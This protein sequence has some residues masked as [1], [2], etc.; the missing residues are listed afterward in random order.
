MRQIIETGRP[1]RGWLGVEIR[2]LTPQL[3]ES[4][5]MD[6]HQGT[7][8]TG[9]VEQGPAQ[10]AGLEVGDV[11][12]GINDQATPDTFSLLQQV[13]R[14]RP[15]TETSITLLRKGQE[16]TRTIKVG[17]RPPPRR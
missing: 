13:A 3:A 4:L 14:I 17:E 8:I 9:L 10:Q 6:T 16:L 15:D 2:D 12:V 1:Q 7:L 11:I 5:E